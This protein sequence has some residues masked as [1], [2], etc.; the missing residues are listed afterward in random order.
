L[1]GLDRLNHVWERQRVVV[2]SL[3]DV[4]TSFIKETS[5]VPIVVAD[6]EVIETPRNVKI[7]LF[8]SNRPVSRATVNP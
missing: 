3:E 8:K 7:I 2:V 4:E 6:I 5:C 1:I